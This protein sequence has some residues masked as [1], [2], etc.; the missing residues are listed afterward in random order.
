MANCLWAV[1]LSKIKLITSI[2]RP[3]MR[4]IALALLLSPLLVVSV[5]TEDPKVDPPVL[6]AGE[7][8]NNGTLSILMEKPVPKVEEK[9]Q[10]ILP[11]ETGEQAQ[12][13]E[14]SIGM[15]IFFIL[16]ILALSIILVHLIIRYKF[17][18][19]PESIAVVALG[20]LVGGFIRLAEKYKMASW[21]EEE[22]FRPN[23]FFLVLLPPIIFESGYSLHKG[24]FFQNIGSI[25]V[26]AVFGTAI[27]A[28]VFGGGI[29]MLGQVAIK[30][31]H[32]AFGSLISAVD[33]VATISILN[34]AVAIVLTK[35]VLAYPPFHH[36]Y[37]HPHFT[38]FFLD[39]RSTPS[40]EFG[41]MIIFAYL[42]YCLAE[43]LKFSGM[44]Q[45]SYTTIVTEILVAPKLLSI[46]VDFIIF[47]SLERS[48]LWIIVILLVNIE[49][50]LISVVILITSPQTLF[51]SLF[52]TTPARHTSIYK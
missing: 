1:L 15:T 34:D 11:M 44:V 23:M 49:V 29:Y 18:I 37:P 26:F 42:P 45:S 27:S 12:R 9:E 25:T 21:K 43:G 16:L 36:L 22:M 13:E 24:N 35:L 52:T 32:F 39:L 33:P 41:I 19:L 48:K 7:K 2:H 38:S 50:Q 4:A 3:D 10:P 8:K 28:A 5:N 31:E 46:H 20:I 51:L 30:W 47:K 40:L 14:Q 17:H 6:S